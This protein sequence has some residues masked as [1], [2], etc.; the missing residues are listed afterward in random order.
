MAYCVV[1]DVQTEFKAVTFSNSTA[2][3]TAQVGAFITQADAFINSRIG[4]IYQT[5]IVSGDGL[6]VLKE[7][8]IKLVSHRIKKILEVKTGGTQAD[9]GEVAN[10]RKEALEMLKQIVDKEIVLDGAQQLGSD[11]GIQSYANE[12]NEEYTFKKGV[13]QW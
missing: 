11:L 5:P 10:D 6:E 7:I 8:S 4:L 13:N 12:N 2:I 3:T 1:A 9:Q